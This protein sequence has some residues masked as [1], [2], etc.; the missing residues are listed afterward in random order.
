M[1]ERVMVS[2]IAGSWLRGSPDWAPAI[3]TE[4]LWFA[5]D[6]L[7]VILIFRSQ[8]QW[9]FSRD[10]LIAGQYALTGDGDVRIGPTEDTAGL[11]LLL[12]SPTGVAEFD[13]NG[14]VVAEF[15]HRTCEIVPVGAENY[16]ITADD[17]AE[18]GKKWRWAW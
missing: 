5:E 3:T 16:Q 4:F 12:R 7:A 1:T 11:Y 2:E 8:E 14:N 17:W 18:L 6:P 15:L 10:L 13:L 9:T